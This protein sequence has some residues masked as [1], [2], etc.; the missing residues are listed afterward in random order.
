MVDVSQLEAQ[1]GAKNAGK[2]GGRCGGRASGERDIWQLLLGGTA[3]LD[4]G[5]WDDGESVCK[6]GIMGPKHAIVVGRSY[7]SQGPSTIA[8]RLS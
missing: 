7:D 5:R 3:Q 8:S 6:D 2:G 1:N 4:S